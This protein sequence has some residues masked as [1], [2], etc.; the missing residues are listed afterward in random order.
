MEKFVI[1]A[2]GLNKEEFERIESIKSL[3]DDEI[4]I[5]LKRRTEYCPY[6]DN[7]TSVVKDYNTRKISHRTLIHNHVKIFYKSR[8]YFCNT[9]R[10]TFMEKNIFSNSSYSKISSFTIINILND[11]KPYTA[12]FSSVARKY[13]ISVNKVIE[14]FDAHVQIKRKKLTRILCL[15]EFYFNR[16]AKNKYAFMIMDFE[17]KNILDVLESRHWSFLSDYFYKIDIKERNSVDIVVIDMYKPYH[18][19]VSQY[20][21]NALCCVDSFHVIKQVND[22]LNAVR[23]RIGR[24]Y[25]NDPKSVN[26]RLLKHRYKLLLKN[27]D[28]IES[29]EYKYDHILGYTTTENGVLELLLK[30]H[31]D[32]KKTYNLKNQYQK[33]NSIEEAKF[34]RDKHEKKLSEI[35]NSMKTSGVKEMENCANTLQN[36]KSE[37]L[38]SFL[39]IDTRRISNG[40]IE[41][42]N[43]YV[44]K[45]L[46]N[47]NGFTNFER[48]RNRIIYSQNYY[49]K[50]S[51]ITSDKPIKR[52]GK[53]RGPYKKRN[54]GK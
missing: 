33:F 23:K 27:E 2:L 20:F 8:R 54:G 47:A 31:P 4:L 17:K 43:N 42:K 7:P 16:H 40:P 52:I 34:N 9:C 50:Y 19:L 32:L 10:K 18:S 22:A 41:G 49:E 36:W 14:I 51:L 26:Y 21:K 39:W 1:K 15:D 30:I 6:C 38:N 44:K 25:K 29:H 48:A 53:P 37:I 13:G 12:T 45:I 3:C 5:T 35:I 11:L 28:D 46:S 24:M